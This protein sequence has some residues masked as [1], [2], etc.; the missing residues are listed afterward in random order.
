MLMYTGFDHA[1]R[2][3]LQSNA[4]SPIEFYTEY[5]DLMR[6]AD[7]SLRPKS[8]D[9]L[10]L[11]YTAPRIDLIV[12]VGSLAFDFMIENGEAIFPGVP[13]VFGSVNASR[14][15]RFTLAEHI[16]GVAVKRD[17]RQ[18][19][20]LLMAIHPD[21]QQVVIPVGSSSTELEWASATRE[22]FQPYKKRVRITY[23]SGLSMNAMLGALRALPEHSAVL[24]TTLFYY[25][26]AGRYFLPEE[27]LASI[28]TQSNAPVYGTDE[29]FL[30]SGIVGGVLYDL[31]PAGDAAGRLGQRVLAGESPSSIPVETIDSNFPMFDARQLERWHIAKSRLPA[32]S[33]I[34]F[35][36]IGPWG[37]YKYYIVGAVS[38]MLLQAVLIIGLFVARA[39]RRRAEASLRASHVRIRDLAGR[40]ITAQEE[41]RSRI[42]R[43]LHDDAGQRIASLSI[44]LS[45]IKRKVV[46]DPPRASND[47]AV[48]QEEMATL[49]NDLRELSH[50][51]HPGMLEHLG[52]VKSLEIRCNEVAAESGIAV[53]LD[54]GSELGTVPP[55][56]ALCLYRV[57]QEALHNVVKHA[58]AGSARVCLA[59]NNG[60][61]H[62][63]V[64][65]D[66]LGFESGTTNGHRGLGLMSLDERV[67]ML[68]GT[69]AIATS[70]RTGTTLS[71]TIPVNESFSV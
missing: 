18:T 30:G 45:R 13:I 39:K 16:T 54:V 10:R 67:R 19:F 9:Y 47:L 27:A 33:V 11:K 71:I 1:F 21:T 61:I 60:T 50:A 64:E 26:A 70:R 22:L 17:L 34:R 63:R 5:L 37:R 20:D 15:E 35:E 55:L 12:A 42:A 41:E 38:L 57:A 44:A 25:D 28:T 43:E 53:R 40:L 24:F 3:R 2:S 62:M 31:Q 4:T 32:G 69:F 14:I 36:E 29:A 68:D 48:V 59:R 49:S 65:D 8:V 66:G 23:L 46:D 56:I 7:P 52:L 51:L 58:H 6:F